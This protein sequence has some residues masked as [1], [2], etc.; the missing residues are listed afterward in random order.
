MRVTWR[1]RYSQQQQQHE[2]EEASAS[3]TVQDGRVSRGPASTPPL[4]PA[5]LLMPGQRHWSQFAAGAHGLPIPGTLMPPQPALEPSFPACSPPAGAKR[6]ARCAGLCPLVV[7]ALLPGTRGFCSWLQAHV[8]GGSRGRVQR[9]L[10][11]HGPSICGQEAQALLRTREHVVVGRQ[12]VAKPRSEKEYGKRKSNRKMSSTISVSAPKDGTRKEPGAV[13][14]PKPRPVDI[15]AGQS[16]FRC[17]Y[18]SYI[19]CFSFLYEL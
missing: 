16:V 6:R 19:C 12:H 7:G 4:P 18:E 1:S 10:G 14:M 2:E 8:P 17:S 3:G 9:G 11:V 13:K 5:L 15:G